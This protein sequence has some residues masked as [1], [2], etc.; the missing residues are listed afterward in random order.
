MKTF[1]L[2]CLLA[3]G[4]AVLAQDDTHEKHK[5]QDKSE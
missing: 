3:F 2:C 5:V 4:T 1:F